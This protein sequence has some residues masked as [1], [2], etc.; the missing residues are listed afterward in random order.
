E[1][2]TKPENADLLKSEIS[3]KSANGKSAI[4]KEIEAWAT[5]N[6]AKQKADTIESPDQVLKTIFTW[7]ADTKQHN[8]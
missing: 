5:G 6:T 7:A 3:A 2:L 8:Q 1:L 4:K